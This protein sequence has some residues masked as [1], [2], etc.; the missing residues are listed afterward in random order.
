MNIAMILTGSR[1]FTG[2][3]FAFFFINAIGKTGEVL[4]F[5]FLNAALITAILLE[6]SDA[7]D[8]VAARTR[9]QVTNFG[10]IFDPICDAISRQ[11]IFLS[12]LLVGAIPV[13]A[14]LAFLYRDS[15]IYLL[16]IMAAKDGTIL[17][18][19][20][21]GKFK[22]ITQA[23]ATFLI[24]IIYYLQYFGIKIPVLFFPVSYYII[25]VA[26]FFALY[27]GIQYYRMN[28]KVI[29]KGL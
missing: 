14:F 3:L 16:R 26:V 20:S 12:F 8:G 4:S 11:T 17:A 23:A 24:I 7:F 15:L 21:F 1:L 9:N 29:L 22:A 6:L 18:A 10:K 28:W 5:A 19:N 25:A 2:A 27:S 13:W